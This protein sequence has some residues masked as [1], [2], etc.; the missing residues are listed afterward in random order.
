MDGYVASLWEHPL[1]SGKANSLETADIVKT[2]IRNDR[3]A[4]LVYAAGDE[5]G[6]WITQRDGHHKIGLI[7]A[8]VNEVE[9]IFKATLPNG[10]S[11]VVSLDTGA[12][13]PPEN[14]PTIIGW[15]KKP[16]SAIDA[17]DRA[18][19]VFSDYLG[20][21]ARLMLYPKQAPRQIREEFSNISKAG[22]VVSFADKFPLL[23][24]SQ[25]T[26]DEIN[27]DMRAFDPTKPLYEMDRFRPNIVLRDIKPFEEDAVAV[28]R[29]GD[30]VMD[31]NLHAPRC[32]VTNIDQ[33]TATIDDSIDGSTG[34]SR[35]ARLRFMK[36]DGFKGVRFGILATPRSPGIIRCSDEIEILEMRKIDKIP[37]ARLGILTNFYEPKLAPPTIG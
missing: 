36:G 27:A 12:N 17:G 15:E 18:A 1:K 5:K 21:K 3:R 22:D 31:C 35:L 9:R 14:L 6:T 16:I 37:K 11:I 13:L 8:E 10:E 20:V 4:V 7:S 33:K 32:E 28:I 2:G 29:I 24:T 19:N 23:V 25:S 30:V 34:L 26:L